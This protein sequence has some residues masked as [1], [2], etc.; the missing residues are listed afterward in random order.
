M[1]ND[2]Q[3]ANLPNGLDLDSSNG[4]MLLIDPLSFQLTTLIA[5]LI[6]KW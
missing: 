5:V 6:L 4:K 1:T 2:T 3:V